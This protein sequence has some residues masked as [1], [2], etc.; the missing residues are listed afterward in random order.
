MSLSKM[1][2]GDRTYNMIYI[3]FYHKEE[4]EGRE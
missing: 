2:K 4:T 1:S 3:S